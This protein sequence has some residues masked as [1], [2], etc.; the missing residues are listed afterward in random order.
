MDIDKLSATKMK[1]KNIFS[2]FSNKFIN[3]QRASKRDQSV[4]TSLNTTT[5]F[6][7]NHSK[8]RIYVSNNNKTSIQTPIPRHRSSLKTFL[9]SHSPKPISLIHRTRRCSINLKTPKR[10]SSECLVSIHTQ[11]LS[12]L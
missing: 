3:Q 4:Q 8:Q 7:K 11:M 5:V 12:S 2:R 1:K 10:L 9:I 6:V